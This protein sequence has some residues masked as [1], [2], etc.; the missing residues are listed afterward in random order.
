VLKE[1]EETHVW[2]RPMM[3]TVGKRL[4]AKSKFGAKLRLCVTSRNG[5]L[6]PFHLTRPPPSSSQRHGSLAQH[7][8]FDHGREHHQAVPRHA[9]I[10]GLRSRHDR[11]GQLLHGRATTHSLGADKERA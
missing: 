10:R 7:A 11:H 9:G 5:S 8:R 3:N 2:F 6:Y 1:F 4:L